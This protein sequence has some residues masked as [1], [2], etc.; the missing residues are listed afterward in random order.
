[1]L[2]IHPAHAP[3]DI[4][5]ARHLFSAYQA[6]LGIDL[7]FQGF[8]AEL[9]QLPGAY[10]PP[11]GC[12]LLAWHAREAVGCV[13]LRA[14]DAK[15]CEMKRLYVQPQARGLGAGRELTRRLV[16]EARALG[17]A[18]MLL[19]TLPSMDAAQ[20]LYRD[21]G[22]RD[23]TPYCH[24]PLPGVRY[25]ALELGIAPERPPPAADSRP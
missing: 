13:A 15:R 20:A 17:Y 1:M 18:E 14:L 23:T 9:A 4:D 25:L 24:N 8:A 7:C 6:Q 22:F 5:I 3:H 12:L 21:L 2:T 10:A 19:D 11:R 16:A